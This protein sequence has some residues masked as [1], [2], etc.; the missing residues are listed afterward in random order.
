MWRRPGGSGGLTIVELM[1]VVALLATLTAVALPVTGD[2]LDLMRT[3]GAARYLS[4]RVMEIRMEAIKRS[5]AVALRFEPAS[6]DY[7]FAAYLDGNGNGIRAAD[8]ARGVDSPLT[9]PERLSDNFRGVVFGLRPEVPDVDGGRT[10]TD[11]VRMG[12][13]RILTMTPS[14]TAT[15]GT[16]YVKGRCGQYAVR[17]LGI[18]GRTRVL[19]YHTGE[20]AWITR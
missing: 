13:A 4:G 1:F 14:G 20:R 7:T 8:I 19:Q 2:A 17:I 10:G 11:G 6:G 5:T 15:S 12:A 9:R 16:L 3:A 18:T